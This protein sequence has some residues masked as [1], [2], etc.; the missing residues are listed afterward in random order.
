MSG[1]QR[2]RGM[3]LIE[4]MIAM[5]IGLIIIAGVIN[6]F[7]ASRQSTR[8][9]DGL[10]DMQDNGRQVVH[11][12][13]DA[14][15]HAGM[16]TGDGLLP[17]NL[18]NSSPIQLTLR[19]QAATDCTGADTAAASEPGIAQNTFFHDPVEDQILCIGDTGAAAMPVADNI[20]DLRFLYGLDEDF[21]P[22]NRNGIER[23]V[24]Y[25]EVADPY[26]IAGIK[27]AVLVTTDGPVKDVAT[28]KTYVVL[29]NTITEN[30]QIGR[31]VFHS[32]AI[33]RNKRE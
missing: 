31:Q 6:I 13:Q 26:E 9:A 30:D 18:A 24:Q 5:V 19:V 10:R 21:D 22:D 3:S 7:I 11:V 25:A 20:Q 16:S 2:Q 4:L 15:L 32:T 27:F 12:L 33:I 1:S 29:D 23:Y 17:V 8:F 14:I 28:N